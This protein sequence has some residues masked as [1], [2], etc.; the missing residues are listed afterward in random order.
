MPKALLINPPPEGLVGKRTRKFNRRFP[1]LSLLITASILREQGWLVEVNDLHANLS[2]S[3]EM[4]QNR[5]KSSDLV[6]VTTN[7][8][9]DWQCPSLNVQAIFDFAK[10]LPGDRLV[11]TGNHGTHYP[12]SVLKETQARVVIREEPEWAIAEVATAMEQGNSFA[13]IDGI[14]FQQQGEVVHN[15]QR[16]L[17]HMDEL[18][19]P[20]YDLVD[21]AHYHYELL[22]GNFAL[23]EAS[24]GCPYSCNFCNL[25]MFQDGYRKRTAE[26]FLEEVDYLVEERGCRSLYIFD[27]EFTINKKLV[28]AVCEHLIEKDY[29]N[30]YGFRWTCQTRADSVNPDLLQMMK[31]S[32]CSLIHFGVEAGNSEIIK[33]TNKRI[34]K[35]KIRE[36]IRASQEAGIQTAGFFIFGHPGESEAHYQETLDFALE[37]SPTFASFHPF[38]SFPGS[39]LFTE[40]FGTGPYWDDAMHTNMMYFTSEQEKATSHFIKKAYLQFYVRPRYIWQ[41]LSRGDW[42][43][44]LR[45]TKLFYAFLMQG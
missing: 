3:S 4:V 34:T 44:Y 11:I 16:K 43:L 31:R 19:R 38:L 39:P 30:R 29:A 41:L 33:N 15:Q 2:L 14:S 22:G 20:A 35:E 8:Y 17:T 37:L 13:E 28:K 23:L 45:Q 5:A 18:P 9:A 21:L 7:P 12:G 25:A 24:R 26:G 27:L 42:G 40:R 10:Q 1:P 6:V 32:G 36:G